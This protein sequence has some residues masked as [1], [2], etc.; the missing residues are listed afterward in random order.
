MCTVTLAHYEQT[1]RLIWQG[2]ELP[3]QGGGCGQ[4]VRIH[5]YTCTPCASNQIEL[6]REQVSRAR[7]CSPHLSYRRVTPAARPAPVPAPPLGSRPTRS[8]GR[9]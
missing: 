3:D 2:M 7:R 9:P 5:G 6:E 1:V 4:R 8:P